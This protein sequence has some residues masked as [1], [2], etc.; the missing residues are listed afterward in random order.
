[1][2]SYIKEDYK[3]VKLEITKVDDSFKFHMVKAREDEK[4][5]KKYED[6]GDKKAKGVKKNAR[7]KKINTA[8]N[9]L[10]GVNIEYCDPWNTRFT[11]FFVYSAKI[12]SIYYWCRQR[13]PL[14]ICR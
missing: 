14:T 8:E 1:M 4:F 13:R 3:R 11:L 10:T 12:F 9:G 2:Y 5:I 6:T 7:V